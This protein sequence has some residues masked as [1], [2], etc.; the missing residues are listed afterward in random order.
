M[1]AARDRPVVAIVNDRTDIA[2]VAGADGVH[3]GQDDLPVHAA[4]RLLGPQS[5]IGVSTHSFEQARQAVRD[6]ANYIGI[7]P[8]FPSKTKQFESWIGVDTMASRG[9]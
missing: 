3:L 4:R 5:I 8:V 7:G 2:A 9:R 6:G 1:Q